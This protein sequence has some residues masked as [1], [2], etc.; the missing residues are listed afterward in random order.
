MRH[1]FR[2][3]WCACHTLT[4]AVHAGQRAGDKRKG[5]MGLGAWGLGQ[6]GGWD[7]A[8]WP[9]A[10]PPSVHTLWSLLV[11]HPPPYSFLLPPSLVPVPMLIHPTPRSDAHPAAA[12]RAPAWR[13]SHPPSP[14]PRLPPHPAAAPW[15]GCARWTVEGSP[16]PCSKRN[17]FDLVEQGRAGSGVPPRQ[18]DEQGGGLRE[19]GPYALEANTHPRPPKSRALPRH[20]PSCLHAGSAATHLSNSVACMKP[21]YLSVAELAPAKSRARSCTGHSA[22]FDAFLF[23]DVAI[24]VEFGRV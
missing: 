21:W 12:P 15:N 17:P 23:F 20:F 13:P 9:S 10:T 2:L 22:M 18:H 7:E 4:S 24:H 5:G 1:F 16:E 8:A 14:S 19:A 6:G 11:T 3:S